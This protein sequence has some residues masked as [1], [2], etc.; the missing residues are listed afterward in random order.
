MYAC[1]VI[2]Q[3]SATVKIGWH[4]FPGYPNETLGSR[5]WRSVALSEK[6]YKGMN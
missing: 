2:V 6:Q 1:L 4:I 3:R 5:E